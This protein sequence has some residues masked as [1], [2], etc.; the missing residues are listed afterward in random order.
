MSPVVLQLLPIDL[1]HVAGS[2]SPLLRNKL[3]T[4]I[5]QCSGRGGI[6]NLL[7][8]HTE[9]KIFASQ[10]SVETW[11]LQDTFIIIHHVVTLV[12]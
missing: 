10:N 12:N 8:I 4:L 3:L 11:P 9:R 2:S 5:L 7:T 6:I 1:A